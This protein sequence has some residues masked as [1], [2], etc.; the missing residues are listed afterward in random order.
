[1]I[2]LNLRPVSRARAATEGNGGTIDAAKLAR[3]IR[4]G[5]AA[6]IAAFYQAV[7]AGIRVLYRHYLPAQESEAEAEA[8]VRA[9]FSAT[10]QAIRR[11]ELRDPEQLWR[12]ARDFVRR[13]IE[14]RGHRQSAAGGDE[15]LRA[16]QAEVM[17]QVLLELLPAEREVLLRYYVRNEPVPEICGATGLTP[18]AVRAL[19]TRVRDRFAELKNR[20]AA[21]PLKAGA[22]KP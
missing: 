3:R 12:F 13:R 15:A 9:T 22:R 18:A 16:E 5:D 2:S 1:M 7:H 11:G 20:G 14:E 8:E 17:R 21:T 4:D 6:G 19:T 10:V